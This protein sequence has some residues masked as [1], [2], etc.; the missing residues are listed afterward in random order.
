MMR[1]LLDENVDQRLKPAFDPDF[2][3]ATVSEQ[4][5][6][7]MKNG[8]LLR[9]AEAEFDVFVTLDRNIQH[10]QQLA[11]YDLAV[12]LIRSRSSRRAD[13]EPA[14]EYVN[15]TVRAAQPGTVS[16]AQV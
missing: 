6:S 8:E 12:V 4:G 14:M 9:A 16:T 1:V 7:G 2:D 3:V 13:I 10:Q 15:Q 11:R 5:W